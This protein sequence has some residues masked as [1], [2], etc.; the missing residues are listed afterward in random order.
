MAHEDLHF[1]KKIQNILLWVFNY[2]RI[3][4]VKVLAIIR[5]L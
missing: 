5:N 1:Y 4:I 2:Y 3:R